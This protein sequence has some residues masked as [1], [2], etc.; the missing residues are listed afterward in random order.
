MVVA[1]PSQ[2]CICVGYCVDA[3]MWMSVCTARAMPSVA[4]ARFTFYTSKASKL[5]PSHHVRQV[6]SKGA[7]DA[8]LSRRGTVTSHACI[9][10]SAAASES[11]A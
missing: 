11:A 6:Q 8:P 9:C 10:Q 4:C 7:G 2:V 5:A 3:M 1:V